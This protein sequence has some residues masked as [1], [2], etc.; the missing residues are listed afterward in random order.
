M[1]AGTYPKLSQNSDLSTKWDMLTKS[2]VQNMKY[3]RECVPGLKIRFK[4]VSH[5]G[6]D[7]GVL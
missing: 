4:L 1:D 7:V 6:I 5:R 3:A 2:L